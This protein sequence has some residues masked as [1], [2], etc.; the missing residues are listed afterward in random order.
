MCTFK[1][2]SESDSFTIVTAAK[3]GS[4]TVDLH[5]PLAALAFWSEGGHD[6]IGTAPV[7]REGTPSAL[8]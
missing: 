1:V 8:W 2:G 4:L 5:N 7:Q 6:T 3:D